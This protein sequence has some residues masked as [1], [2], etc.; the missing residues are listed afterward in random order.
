VCSLPLPHR[1]GPRGGCSWGQ[2]GGCASAYAQGMSA[3]PHPSSTDLAFRSATDGLSD[4]R[5]GDLDSRTLV[6]TLASRIAAIDA[7]NT[8]IALRSVLALSA[9][10]DEQI[11]RAPISGG[12]LQGMPVMIKDNIEARGLPGTAGSL[13][14][15]GRQVRSDSPLV[16]RLRDAGAIVM[17]ATNL[18][19]WANIRST[20]STSGWSA[21]GGLTANPWALDRSAGGSSSGSGAAVAAGLVPWAIGTE[22][23]G[24]ITCP[25]ALNGVVGIKPTVGSVSTQGVVPVSASQDVPGPLARSV[26][27]AALLL[28]VISGMQGLVHAANSP[29]PSSMRVG[30][31]RQWFTGHAATDDL[32]DSLVPV[33]EGL[34]VAVSDSAAPSMPD[35]IG[36]AEYA[37]LIAEL[38]D[39]LGAFLAARPEIGLATLADVVEF[40]RINAERE[41]HLFGQEI[42][43]MAM[44][45]GGRSAHAYRDAQARAVGWAR[46]VCLEP[47]FAD[48]DVLIAPAYGPA[49]KNDFVLGHAGAVGGKVTSPAAILGWPI[50][51]IPCGVLSGLPV[52]LSLVGRAG[53]EATL[54]GLAATLESALAL[55]MRPAFVPVGRG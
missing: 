40:N 9:D 50:V 2:P 3:D 27:D 29:V 10:L 54:I 23:D 46:D 7:S 55:T 28:E 24:S 32:V 42:F 15:R 26:R 38:N 25:A 51:T 11:D 4:L 34:G 17:G 44:A 48:A 13:A 35:D 6:D 43:E 20:N 18:S 8:E 41:L 39:D 5:S 30:V 31:A 49:W 47:A 16:T 22:T 52:G 36:E 21:A 37:I 12:V 14:L 1:D 53:S 45:S 33:I 19:E